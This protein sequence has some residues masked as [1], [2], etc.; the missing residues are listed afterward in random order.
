M[1]LGVQRRRGGGLRG[2]TLI[3]LMVALVVLVVLAGVAWPLYAQYAKRTYRLEAQADLL[4]CAQGLERLAS[5]TFSYA[6]AADPDGEDQEIA[7]ALS[8]SVCT[9][10]SEARYTLSVAADATQFLLTA[11]PKGSM[12]GDGVLTLDSAGNRGWDRDGDGT[13]EAD[14][15]EDRWER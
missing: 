10:M 5:D 11:T 12:A 15:G 2:F 8:D 7:G 6:S 9:V 1:R 3:E 14:A 13:V 4:N